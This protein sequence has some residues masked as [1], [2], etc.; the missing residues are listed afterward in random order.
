MSSGFRDMIADQ[1]FDQMLAAAPSEEKE[2]GVLRGVTCEAW[3][4]VCD[5]GVFV[6]KLSVLLRTS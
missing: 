4:C 5:S 6:E 1:I 3:L 2:V